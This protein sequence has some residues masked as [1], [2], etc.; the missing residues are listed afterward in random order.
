MYKQDWDLKGN[1]NKAGMN[2]SNYIQQVIKE[3]LP[4][5]SEFFPFKEGYSSN[6]YSEG[7]FYCLQIKEIISCKRELTM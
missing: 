4:E 2:I 1:L 6:S 5:Y 3:Q 7:D